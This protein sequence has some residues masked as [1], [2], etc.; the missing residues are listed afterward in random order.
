MNSTNSTIIEYHVQETNQIVA[1]LLPISIALIGIFYVCL[2]DKCSKKKDD[3]DPIRSTQ[4]LTE[5]V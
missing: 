5:L 1:V 2:K 3:D 4:P